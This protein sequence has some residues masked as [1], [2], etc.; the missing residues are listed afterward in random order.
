MLKLYIYIHILTY[1]RIL[2]KIYSM[3][4]YALCENTYYV[5]IYSV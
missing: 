4:K 3:R 1:F 5:K 2:V